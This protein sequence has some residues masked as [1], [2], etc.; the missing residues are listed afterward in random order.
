MII[1]YV[2]YPFAQVYDRMALYDGLVGTF[3]VWALY[4][5]MLLIRKIKLDI[6]YTLGFVIGGGILTKSSNFFSIYL[7]PFLL[8]LFD[9]KQKNAQRKLL[10]LSCCHSGGSHKLWDIH[11]Q[12]LSPLYRNDRH[13]KRHVCLPVY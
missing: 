8:I 9:F 7:L 6:A 10:I 5:S 12:R 13:Q 4:F 2:F 3:Y 11:I 1:L